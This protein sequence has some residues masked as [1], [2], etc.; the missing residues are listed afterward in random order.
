[1]RAR[2]QRP[3]AGLGSRGRP[4]LTAGRAARA[5]LGGG[6][7]RSRGRPTRAACSALL[8]SARPSAGRWAR[9]RRAGG[10]GAAPGGPCRSRSCRRCAA[11]AV[12]GCSALGAAGP[13]GGPGW[14]CRGSH[15]V[16]SPRAVPVV[17]RSAP[18]GARSW[19]RGCCARGSSEPGFHRLTLRA[20]L[21]LACSPEKWFLSLTELPYP[22]LLLKLLKCLSHSFVVACN[23]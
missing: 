2:A 6:S 7:G 4:A 18:G 15:E 5:P 16:L 22:L 13:R 20:E 19:S 10:G 9:G 12:R 21:C 14:N 8:R 3:S 23:C 11:G 17:G 1:M